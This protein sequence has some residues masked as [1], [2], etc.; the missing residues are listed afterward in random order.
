MH[1]SIHTYI[2][3]YSEKPLALFFFLLNVLF[4]KKDRQKTN[5]SCKYKLYAIQNKRIELD[6]IDVK[7]NLISFLQS[8]IVFSRLIKT[9]NIDIDIAFFLLIVNFMISNYL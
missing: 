9:T 7:N 4:N 1:I 2:C 3:I 5:C 8:R 6:E